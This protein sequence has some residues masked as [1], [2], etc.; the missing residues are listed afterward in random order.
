[1]GTANHV[2]TKLTDGARVAGIWSI[3]PSPMVCEIQAAAGLD[4]LILDMEHGPFDM[5][6]LGEAIRAT[7]GYAC[8][9]LVRIPCI[10]PPLIQRVLDLGAHGIVA[11][12]VRTAK[13]ARKLVSCCRFAPDGLRGYN[14]F[15][16][17]GGFAADPTS[18]YLDNNFPLVALIIEN[19]EAVQNLPEILQVEGIDVLY[20]GT[21]DM[22]CCLGVQGCMEHSLVTDFANS[23]TNLI[24]AAG[25]TVG[26]MVERMPAALD[27]ADAQFL[28]LKPDTYLLHQAISSRL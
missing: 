13:D 5:A 26:K 23:A 2:K 8:S 28:V 14:P 17:S 9:P 22:S 1:M 6:V 20:L 25:R 19:L 4:F 7:A 12:Q 15:T 11:P 3:I 24:H 18:P 16:R 21:Y 10:D 27:P